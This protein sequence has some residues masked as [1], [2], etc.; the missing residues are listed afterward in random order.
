ML[1]NVR[2]FNGGSASSTL[3]GSHVHAPEPAEGRWRCCAGSDTEVLSECDCGFQPELGLT[4]GMV[5]VHVESILLA[6]EEVE[7]ETTIPKDRRTHPGSL[8]HSPDRSSHRRLT[9]SA[10]AA[11]LPSCPHP[12]T[13]PAVSCRRRLGGPH[14][15]DGGLCRH[16][17]DRLLVHALHSV[18]A[19]VY[20]DSS[21]IP[22]RVERGA[23]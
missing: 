16:R 8:H 17:L 23:G 19:E 9:G 22:L 6:R 14:R 10:S 15:R 5:N 20:L 11:A 2:D 7:S 21:I 1:R 18:C 3:R 4:G 13:L 12:S